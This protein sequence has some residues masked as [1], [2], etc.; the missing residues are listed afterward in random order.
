[1]RAH[2]PLL[3]SRIAGAADF[4]KAVEDQ[5]WMGLPAAYVVPLDEE[6]DANPDGTGLDQHVT[7][8]IAVI[9]E[10]DNSSDRRGQSV[11]EQYEAM[12]AA[13]W[14][15]LLNW[16]VDPLN[17]SQ[18]LCYAGGQML[19][20]DRARLFYQYEFTLRRL[21]TDM[22]G[23]QEPVYPLNEIDVKR[24]VVGPEIHVVLPQ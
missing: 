10:Y 5:G 17:A 20:F 1:M 14:A 9:V 4:A 6:A 12:R 16:R 15:A 2:I 23:Y 24:P 11:A 21:L 22:D 13:I 3:G 18:G 19:K 7:E 8:R